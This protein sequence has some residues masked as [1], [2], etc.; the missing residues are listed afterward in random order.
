MEVGALMLW[1]INNII[2]TPKH[3][4]FF[5]GDAHIISF[6]QIYKAIQMVSHSIRIKYHEL[7]CKIFLFL[8]I[9]MKIF[10]HFRYAIIV[11]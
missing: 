2:T 5:Q 6:I 10:L 7:V 9:K 8:Q 3:H 11:K 4:G 1:L